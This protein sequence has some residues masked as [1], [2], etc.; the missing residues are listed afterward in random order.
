VDSR[1][2]LLRM[3]SLGAIPSEPASLA[4]F[5]HAILYVPSLDWYLDGTAEFHG[6]TELPAADRQASILVV[7]PNGPSRFT[8]T[9]P[10]AAD[11]NVTDVRL[12]LS[13]PASRHGRRQ[14]GDSHPR[15]GRVGLP[16]QLPDARHAQD[17][18][19]AGLVPGLPGPL[20]G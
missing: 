10:A 14:G 13:L 6:A 17:E 19:G 4:V 7:E 16:A 15:D 18:P 2:V 11:G 20:G 5:N 8:T 12:E 3:R 9:P 1:I